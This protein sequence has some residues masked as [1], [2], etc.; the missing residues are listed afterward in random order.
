MWAKGFRFVAG[1]VLLAGLAGC[2]A[3]GRQRPN[4]EEFRIAY[5]GGILP[6]E[7]EAWQK[8]KKQDTLTGYRDF[9]RAY[10]SSQF[11][12]AAEEQVEALEWS[13]AIADGSLDRYVFYLVHH[14]EG[15]RAEQARQFVRLRIAQA[16]GVRLPPGSELTPKVPGTRQPIQQATESAD[17]KSGQVW[18]G[19]VTLVYLDGSW[20]RLPG[21]V[22]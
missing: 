6:A 22:P 19:K 8:A 5:P 13:E 2:A 12:P 17:L 4:G 18:R 11:T 3:S 15:K 10:P 7:D 21:D 1:V 20:Y 14:P 9:V 16:G